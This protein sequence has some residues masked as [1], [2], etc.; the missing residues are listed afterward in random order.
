METKREQLLQYYRDR[1]NTKYHNDEEF[2]RN[3]CLKSKEYYY[4]KKM[5]QQEQKRQELINSLKNE[6]NP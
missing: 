6:Q 5:K 1:Y 4:N 2:R 3:R